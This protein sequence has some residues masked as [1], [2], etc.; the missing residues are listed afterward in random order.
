MNTWSSSSLLNQVWHEEPIRH[1]LIEVFEQEL[2]IPALCKKPR[3]REAA[4][5]KST[6]SREDLGGCHLTTSTD[7]QTK[8]KAGTALSNGLRVIDA[9]LYPTRRYLR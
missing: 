4:G 1:L 3:Q 5:A 9:Q 8:V 2:W 6:S 7:A